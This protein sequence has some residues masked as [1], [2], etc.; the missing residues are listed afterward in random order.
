MPSLKV[1]LHY[2]VLNAGGA[3]RSTLRLLA[4]LADRGCEVHLV[5]TV[6]GGQL[7][8]E[9]DPRVTVHHLRDTVGNLPARI[10]GIGSAWRFATG[11][12]QWVRGRLQQAWRSR[13]FAGMRFD[14]AIVGLHGLSPAFVC[15][16]TARC[17]LVMVRSDAADDGLGRLARNIAAYESRIDHYV[18]VSQSVLDSLV[19][20][21]PQTR[22]KAIRIY[23][24]IDPEAMRRAAAMATNPFED[25]ESVFRVISVCRLQESQ[26]ALLRMVEVHR[27]LLGTGHRHEWHVLGD[28]PDRSLLERAI[29]QQGVAGTFILH[30]AVAN[31]LRFYPYADVCAVLS[32]IEGLSGVVNE[33]RVLERPLIATRFAGIEE[34]VTHGVN[35]WIAEQDVQSICD[36]LARLIRDPALR[37]RLA[38]G[39]YPQ[40]L[41][42]DELKL[43]ALLELIVD[44]S[45]AAAGIR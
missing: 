31:P 4:G 40:A 29:A 17:R 38:R 43:D 6:A 36:G 27:R 34:Q 3:E 13:H 25:T 16:L 33:A 9:I 24:L 11:A 22:A 14:A 32:Y 21:F 30:G 7:E 18:C 19:G 37:E 23:N 41:L 28:G 10:S 15:R 35:G 5:L 45:P 8:H 26:K 44:A 20:R 42:D 12:V 2:P 39:G 1:L